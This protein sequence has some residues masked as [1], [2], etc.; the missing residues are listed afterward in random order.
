M[1]DAMKTRLVGIVNEVLVGRHPP[2]TNHERLELARRI[3][4]RVTTE[5]D[6]AA[7]LAHASTLTLT[8]RACEA[9]FLSYEKQHLAKGTEEGREKARTNRD[10][11]D[12]IT[13]ALAGDAPP[14]WLAADMVWD[15]EDPE[16][17]GESVEDLYAEGVFDDGNIY[18]VRA[19]ARVP[20]FFV[21]KPDLDSPLQFFRSHEAAL[22][23]AGVDA[24]VN[25]VTEGE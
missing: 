17:G 21:W 16:N 9:Q 15:H 13:T 23:A 6:Y 24:V 3:V 25:D 18:Q 19:A 10:F 1:R 11:A 12:T 5:Y 22:L 14:P 2:A 20:D 4:A 7:L 8:L